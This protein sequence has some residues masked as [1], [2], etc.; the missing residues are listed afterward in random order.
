MALGNDPDRVAR[1]DLVAYMKQHRPEKVDRVDRILKHFEG[2]HGDLRKDLQAK[3][4]SEP[5]RAEEKQLFASAPKR[6]SSSR[7][8]RFPSRSS[9]QT[10]MPDTGGYDDYNDGGEKEMVMVAGH[11]EDV[12]FKGY[13]PSHD[14]ASRY[15][16]NHILPQWVLD[17]IT[18]KKRRATLGEHGYIYSVLNT[19][20]M[21]LMHFGL[22][23]GLYFRLLIDLGVL[24][25]IVAMLN[26]VSIKYFASDAYKHGSELSHDIGSA[27]C[28]PQ[29]V[30]IGHNK[31]LDHN[32]CELEEEQ[33]VLNMLSIMLFFL[34]LVVSRSY[35]G[36]IEKR[37]DE[38]AQTAQDYSVMCENPNANLPKKTSVETALKM[39]KSYFE[40][41]GG[42]D[43]DV[44]FLTVAVDN[45]KLLNLLT[46]FQ[47]LKVEYQLKTGKELDESNVRAVAKSCCS[48]LCPSYEAITGLFSQK[49]EEQ[50]QAKFG[51]LKT[52]IKAELDRCDAQQ[53]YDI[54]KVYCTFMKESSQRRCL[55]RLINNP[56]DFKFRVN[57]SGE[58][59]TDLE[60][61]CTELPIPNNVTR[62]SDN[63]TWTDSIPYNLNTKVDENGILV[64]RALIEKDAD[65]KIV[66]QDGKEVI[67]K[68]VTITASRPLIGERVLVDSDGKVLFEKKSDG[69][70]WSDGVEVQN[71]SRLKVKEACEPSDVF[72]CK[73]G[74]TGFLASLKSTLRKIWALILC[75]LIIWG[76]TIV[77]DHTKSSMIDNEA[78]DSHKGPLM[79]GLVIS[80]FNFL[81]P[82]IIGWIC[83]FEDHAT[84]TS[85][86]SSVVIKLLAVRCINSAF[87]NFHITDYE[88]T[89]SEKS[90]ATIQ[91]ILL[92]D[93]FFT[94]LLHMIDPVGIVKRVV[95]SRFAVTQDGL[96]HLYAGSDWNLAD[97]YTD[98]IKTLFVAMFYSVLM[99][100]GLWLAAFAMAS[101]FWADKYCLLRCWAQKPD[102]STDI[103]KIAQNSI[104]FCLLIQMFMATYWISGYP[105][106]NACHE[107]G[108]SGGWHWK[109]CDRGSHYDSAM[110]WILPSEREDMTDAQKTMVGHYG[111]M[112]VTMIAV[113]FFAMFFFDAWK[114][115]QR[116]WIG[117]YSNSTKMFNEDY[118][119]VPH[120][121]AFVPMVQ[122]SISEAPMLA[123]PL[124]DD[125]EKI[126]FDVEYSSSY[127]EHSLYDA[128]QDFIES[129]ERFFGRDRRLN[130]Q[131]YFS[132]CKQYYKN[133]LHREVSSHEDMSAVSTSSY[134]PRHEWTHDDRFGDENKSLRNPFKKKQGALNPLKRFVDYLSSHS[135]YACLGVV[136]LIGV[137]VVGCLAVAYQHLCD[138]QKQLVQ[139]GLCPN[140]Y[141]LMNDVPNTATIGD[142]K[143]VDLQSAEGAVTISPAW[144]QPDVAPITQV[145]VIASMYARNRNRAEG[146][147]AFNSSSVTDPQTLVKTFSVEGNADFGTA[148]TMLGYDV[149]CK[150]VSMNVAVPLALPSFG[151]L[152]VEVGQSSTIDADLSDKAPADLEQ[153]ASATTV[154]L[155][156]TT[157][158]FDRLSLTSALGPIS[159]R[160][161][162]TSATGE[163]EVI[164]EN[165]LTADTLSPTATATLHNVQVKKA[166]VVTQSAEVLASS[167]RLMAKGVLNITTTSGMVTI[168]D[169]Y[170]LGDK[171]TVYVETDTADI[172]ITVNGRYF[173]GKY[174]LQSK[175][176]Q[177]WTDAGSYFIYRGG[178]PEICCTKG[179]HGCKKW[180][181]LPLLRDDV[182]YEHDHCKQGRV[183]FAYGEQNIIAY[184]RSGN[185]TLRVR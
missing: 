22:G 13:K 57:K 145:A 9:K 165:G 116:E 67:Y 101:T 161:F 16:R 81:L 108:S 99:P 1:E 40:H 179:S 131:R 127:E 166:T 42:S 103:T 123:C 94:P 112:N 113:V 2:R 62:G 173:H 86:Q 111:I 28:F 11:H 12:G 88:K 85:L 100:H 97:R 38:S 121:R 120:I 91:A 63:P 107:K 114:Y 119:H 104:A 135:C 139:D 45:C 148:K 5:K 98:M 128:L 144:E 14:E 23:V 182:H 147:V 90:L 142:I 41:V 39:F 162:M 60:H 132:A 77:V 125:R 24:L 155:A 140:P 54:T 95:Y 83:S 84:H 20:T 167:V 8:V 92:W 3:Y 10:P 183:G 4:G 64:D 55:E 80:A 68:K 18:N 70:L 136:I 93:M 66:M 153:T 178:A 73:L 53:G 185:V 158:S 33:G 126:C 71:A 115:I 159:V 82:G 48:S 76:G 118:N 160:N 151:S 30:P 37:A 180:E 171:G 169:L 109:E 170:G 43:S 17:P 174:N 47:E 122:K 184:S 143:L 102:V 61:K 134:G 117:Y 141:C 50:W 21:E 106:D 72:W 129:D 44:A 52:M 89:L 130:V 27:A 19:P 65:L 146:L 154:E 96:N 138:H 56:N 164:T 149:D 25:A 177:V 51:Q 150:H 176:G 59:V 6:E 172:L 34:Y 26:T 175:D 133:V 36:W 152:S 79:V 31:T 105:F 32:T 78:H 49:T 168:T 15:R 163:L 7:N 181:G 69:S 46:K 58:L 35:Y 74:N 124:I 29:S 75:V 110:N 157:T 156:S 137:F 87:I